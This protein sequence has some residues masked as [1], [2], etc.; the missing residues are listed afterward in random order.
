VLRRRELQLCP[1]ALVARRHQR[2]AQHL[3]VV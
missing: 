3:L 2:R 1:I